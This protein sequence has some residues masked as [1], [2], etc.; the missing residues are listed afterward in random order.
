MLQRNLNGLT[1][2][3]AVV[4]TSVAILGA[5]ASPPDLSE[6]RASFD[7]PPDE[8]P[9]R[10]SQS[11]SESD[12]GVQVAQAVEE[13]PRLGASAANIRAAEARADGSGRAF[14]PRL[15]LGATVGTI[16]GGSVSNSGI[17]PV[18]RVLQLVYD[19]GESASRR[20]AAQA[21]VFDAR[22]AQQEVA[23]ALALDAVTAWHDL[24]AARA[25]M[26]VSQANLDSHQTF[27]DQANERAEA[28]V[29]ASADVLTARARLST[30]RSRAAEARARVDSAEAAFAESFGHRAP[31]RLPP[32]SSAPELPHEPDSELVA[33]SPRIRGVEAR[34]KAAEAEVAIA[35]AQRFPQ[36]Q[37]QG[38]GQ[39]RSGGGTDGRVDLDLSYEPGA[40]GERAAAISA[41]EAELV[42]VQAERQMLEREIVRALADLR[43]DRRAGAARLEAARE[44]VSANEE[45]VDAAREEF[46]IGRRTLIGLLDAQ[47]DLFESTETLIAAERELALSGYGA[48]ALTGDILD[49]FAI[50][51]P[52]VRQ[53]ENGEDDS[54]EDVP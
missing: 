12:F 44:A 40:P 53:H 32:P 9:I 24:R 6:I 45:T 33:S 4:S 20:V 14:L 35:R 21:R 54:G 23:A 25:R 38:T 22:G 27:L 50:S 51:L 11:I 16:L 13:H 39:R 30:A 36:L 29:G 26:R 8:R 37:A 2:I 1:R 43:T 19:G 10:V 49:A 42:V 46:S 47:R 15:S 41:A 17:N 7:S 5:C 52:G 3:I 18:L 34:I 48:L 31:T 28:G